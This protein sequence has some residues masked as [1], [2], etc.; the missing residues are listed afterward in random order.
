MANCLAVGAVDVQ[1]LRLLLKEPKEDD[2][3]CEPM[4]HFDANRSRKCADN[5]HLSLGTPAREHSKAKSLMEAVASCRQVLI[6]T[7]YASYQDQSLG[8]GQFL[9]IDRGCFLTLSNE[10][11]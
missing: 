7:I 1:M 6:N 2:S 3:W 10:Y 8:E 11:M 5:G 4:F 9:Y